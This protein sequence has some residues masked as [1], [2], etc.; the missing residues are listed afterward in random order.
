[1]DLV[2]LKQRFQ[3]FLFFKEIRMS[4][5]N[6]DT[7][8]G[9]KRLDIPHVQANSIALGVREKPEG[10]PLPK[11]SSSLEELQKYLQRAAVIDYQPDPAHAL[12]EKLKIVIA[13]S[14][15][16]IYDDKAVDKWMLEM[17][18]KKG[19]GMTWVWKSLTKPLEEIAK[20]IPACG[21]FVINT[22]DTNAEL[23][24]Q[25]AILISKSDTLKSSPRRCWLP[26]KPFSSTL[27][28]PTPSAFWCLITKW[29]SPT[30]S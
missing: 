1:M 19:P 29:Y 12:Y 15:I 2:C 16:L 11:P 8:Q 13:K 14:N 4:L 10:R 18:Q 23:I 30:P 20:K 9:V 22:G 3:G 26:P 25:W 21:I 5:S 6:I 28:K 17:V 27:K 24:T 7:D